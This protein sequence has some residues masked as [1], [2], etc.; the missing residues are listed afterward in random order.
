MKQRRTLAVH[1]LNEKVEFHEKNIDNKACCNRKSYYKMLDRMY[2]GA[3]KD[4]NAEECTAI[5]RANQAAKE[6]KVPKCNMKRFVSYC[7]LMRQI[8]ENAKEVQS[9]LFRSSKNDRTCVMRAMETGA[10]NK[11]PSIWCEYVRLTNSKH[12]IEKIHPKKEELCETV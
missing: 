4:E 5:A 7:V 9:G 11:V 8:N 10:G 2:P 6:I 12:F 1:F 3:K